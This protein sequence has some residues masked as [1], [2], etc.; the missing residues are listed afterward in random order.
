LRG[1]GRSQFDLGFPPLVQ[2]EGLVVF[3]NVL[4][5]PPVYLPLM[6]GIGYSGC[7]AL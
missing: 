1:L 4:S 2:I 6:N 5:G 3:K 7:E